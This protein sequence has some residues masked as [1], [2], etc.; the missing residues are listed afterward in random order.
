MTDRYLDNILETVGGTPLVKLNN[1]TKG[2]EATV[3]AKVE[4]FNPGGSVKDRIAV[5]IIQAA[6]KE[7]LLKP[8]GT[9]VEATSGNTGA[10]L[11]LVAALKGYKAI[12]TMPDKMSSEKILNLRA[13][14]A[15]VIVTPTA[16]PADSP[17]SYYS[18]A[19]KIVDETPNALLANQYFNPVNPESHY[20]STGP[21]IWEQTQG[22][23]DYFV[24]GM[25]TGGTISGVG[26]FLKEKNP[27]V[28]IVGAD[29]V[30][31]ILKDYFY[32]KKMTEA[33]PYKVEG[34]GED[35]I[36]GTTHFEYIDEVVK[37]SD[38]ESFNIARR[39]V[40]EEGI[41]IGGSCGLAAAAALKVAARLEK[42]Q[43]LVVLFPDS[44]VKYLSTF[45]SDDWMRENRF[46][47]PEETSL[48]KVLGAKTGASSSLIFVGP[49][50]TV[51]YAIGQMKVHDISQ[52]PVFKD[53]RSIGHLE[54]G[55]IMARV[56]EDNLL[57]DVPVEE[58]M[59]DSLPVMKVGQK[60]EAAKRF[61][62]KDFPAVLVEDDT[63]IFGIITKSDLL[64]FITS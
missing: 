22:Q 58:V 24:A 60:I 43:I 48:D 28:Q 49:G 52:I 8:G 36:P 23:I 63:G 3:L 4:F 5:A 53:G 62:S 29:P 64:E 30:G 50:D 33:Q 57:F 32:T 37:V 40:R 15:E 54:E 13:F 42:G 55:E 35:I 2:I 45:F 38:K 14:G 17:E 44:G 61:L 41:L 25:G 51:R 56:I 11:A 21:E 39:I 9:I 19:Q 12:F 18:V 34:V 10:G 26:R 27:E 47:D 20:L 46:L 59:R 6:E 7:G 1:V 31:S 16:V